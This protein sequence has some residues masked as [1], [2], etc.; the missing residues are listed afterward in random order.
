MILRRVTKHVKDQNWFAV[1]LDF[2]IV[3]VGI[4]IAFQ[5]TNWSNARQDNLIYEQARTRV[6]EEA[7]VNLERANVLAVRVREFEASARHILE[8]FETC[9]ADDDAEG[10]LLSALQII[11][12]Y[13]GMD[14]RDDAVTQLLTSDAFLDNLSPEDRT[15]LSLYARRLNLLAQNDQFS[16]DF[17][18]TR[19]TLQ[20]NPVFKRTLRVD[21]GNSLSGIALNVRYEEACRDASLNTF[22][23]DRLEHGTYVAAQTGVFANAA[24]EVLIGLGEAVRERPAQEEAP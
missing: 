8:D 17:Q 7:R 1:G 10:R 19:P 13:I 11:R 22:L 24:R 23:F 6:I 9:S 15:I 14:V 3:V 5:I 16:A 21:S 18:L 12:F 20:D 4:L 2:C